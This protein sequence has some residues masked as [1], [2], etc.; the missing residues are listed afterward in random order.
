MKKPSESE[1]EASCLEWLAGLGWR[2]TH[3][4]RM[5]PDADYIERTSYDQVILERRLQ[6][7]SGR[8]EPEFAR[9]GVDQMPS[10][11]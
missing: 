10:T 11:N 8:I 3:G 6:G 7:G 9:A 1:V 4:S 2:V 5:A